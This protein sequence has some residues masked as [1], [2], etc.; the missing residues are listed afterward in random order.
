MKNFSN[1]LFIALLVLVLADQGNIDAQEIQHFPQLLTLSAAVN[2]ALQYQ[3][4]LR[5]AN[6]NVQA[7]AAS[8]TLARSGYYPVV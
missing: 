6:A 1:K 2:L 3:P 7:S 8:L 5:V 4:N